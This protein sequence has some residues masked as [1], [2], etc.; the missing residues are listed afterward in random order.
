MTFAVRTIVV[1]LALGLLLVGFSTVH[2][3]GSNAQIIVNTRVVSGTAL[4]S[5]LLSVI[6]QGAGPSLSSV[7]GA[8]GTLTF[9]STF[10]NA[11][12]V[13]TLIPSQYSVRAANNSGYVYSYSSG[14]SGSA[15]AGDVKT[16]TIT[17]Y[18]GGLSGLTVYTYVINN[19]GGYRVPSD[20]T[21]KV[22]GQN[23]TPSSFLGSSSGVTVNLDSGAFAVEGVEYSG[24][25][26]TMSDS[27]SGFLTAGESRTCTVTYDDRG[28]VLGS[29]SDRLVCSPSRQ[30]V[31]WGGTATFFADGGVG[32]YNWTTADRT[33][34][35]IGRTLNVI[36]QSVGTQTVI[37]T[38]G[39]QTAYCVVDVYASGTS[40]PGTT[41]YPPVTTSGTVIV[42]G[43][44]GGI[45]LG[46][47][48]PNLPNTGFGPNPLALALMLALS[49]GALFFLFP[50][51][52]GTVAYIWR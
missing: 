15:F 49:F 36:L 34:L 31:A 24:Y 35:N 30:S 3:Q 17:A 22:T 18:Q 46:T 32:T 7:P 20:F 38:S 45:V 29:V 39:S 51:V 13:V 50:Y 37:V 40:L 5:S 42:G 6:V 27:C 8:L 19:N 4:P 2:A 1:F 26:K 9:G 33:F 16:C 23:A 12:H 47:S 14:C 41:Y 43:T 48:Y 21:M 52:R 25:T 44:S 10:N 28:S 11:T